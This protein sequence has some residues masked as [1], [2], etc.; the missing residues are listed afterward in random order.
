M[1]EVIIV[2]SGFSGSVLARRIAEELGEKV[3]VIE[4]RSHIGGNAY[5]EY[6][7]RGILVQKYG[8]HFLNTNKYEIIKYLKQYAKLFPHNTKLLSYLDDRYIRLPFNFQTV[9]ELVGAEKSQSLLNTLRESFVGRDRVPIL[10]LVD[11]KDKEVSDY[12]NLLFEKAYKTYTAK[13]W[14][15]SVDEIDKYVLDRVPMAMNYDERYLNKDFQY[16]PVNGFNEIFKNML[17]HPNIDVRLNEDALKSIVINENEKELFFEG[18]KVRCMIFT[19]A[20]D[21]LFSYKFGQL[22]YRSL[23]IKYEYYDKD[24]VLP[25]EII[26]YP[27]SVGFTRSTEYRQIM[28]SQENVKGTVVAT[29]YPLTFDEKNEIANIRYYPVNTKESDKVYQ[30]YLEESKKFG[31]IF[32]C[33]RLAE[34]K[35]YNMDVCIEHALEYFDSIKSFL[36]K[37]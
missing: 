12:G 2:G 20:I 7:E 32:L 18:K 21:E 9:Q 11:H 34:F 14:G 36:E 26:S 29:E 5:D 37:N 16:L 25:C 3:T 22:P 30:Q 19:G 13:M 17:N 31:N 33:G 1:G 35:Y 27:Q 15:L 8:P 10:D 23:D 4:K 24:K 6:D 28:F